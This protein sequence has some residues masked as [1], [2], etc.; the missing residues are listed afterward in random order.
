MSKNNVLK[1]YQN[2][3]IEKHVE[4]CLDNVLNNISKTSRKT[5]RKRLEKHIKKVLRNIWKRLHKR[6]YIPCISNI[7]KMDINSNLHERCKQF[8]VMSWVGE[9]VWWSH[10]TLIRLGLELVNGQLCVEVNVVTVTNG[11]DGDSG[12]Q[13]LTKKNESTVWCDSSNTCRRN[14]LDCTVKI[15]KLTCIF[16]YVW[17]STSVCVYD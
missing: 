10:P 16:L 14:V 9:G 12:V 17:H 11:S 13:H 4:K 3:R 5:Y 8:L 6:I 7:F 15:Y 2:T 1:T